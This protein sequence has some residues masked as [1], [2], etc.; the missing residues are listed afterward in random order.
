MLFRARKF[1]HT[2]GS[3]AKAQA[4]GHGRPHS[5]LKTDA[6]Y[7]LRLTRHKP[8]LFLDEYTCCLELYRYFPVSLTTMHRTFEHAGLHVKRVQKLASE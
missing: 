1:K 2:T 6:D 5:L 7:L 4:I 8:T 3:V